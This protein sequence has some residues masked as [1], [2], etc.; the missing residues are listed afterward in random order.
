M[1][2]VGLW[3]WSYWH[4]ASVTRSNAKITAALGAA[5][6]KG[7]VA[8]VIVRLPE[9]G[10]PKERISEIKIGKAE[11]L[12]MIP[13]PSSNAE[14][15]NRR[16]GFTYYSLI[17][18]QFEIIRIVIFPIW[19][20]VIFSSLPPIAWGIRYRR[21]RSPPR[22]LQHLWL[23]SSGEHRSMPRMR[24]DDRTYGRQ[25][26]RHGW[27]RIK[28]PINGRHFDRSLGRC[29]VFASEK[30]RSPTALQ[31]CTR[32]AARMHLL[33]HRRASYRPGKRR[34]IT[35]TL[36]LTGEPRETT[37][38]RCPYYQTTDVAQRRAI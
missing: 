34:A 16:G 11:D 13:L 32:D 23:R 15:L 2:L 3:V 25:N 36:Q 27:A 4:Y 21:H 9:G 14:T 30:A 6:S 7:K 17:I 31:R 28:Q 22:L 18:P 10:F 24:S 20:L 5:T 26:Y 19:T 35:P 38:A 37:R 8:V 33:A 29:S 1:G 12:D